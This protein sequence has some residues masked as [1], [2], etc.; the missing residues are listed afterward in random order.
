MRHRVRKLTRLLLH[1]ED[2]H[3]RTALAFG[4]GVFIGLSPLIG[5]H[6]ALGLA[7]AVFFRLNRVAV[8]LGVYVNNPWTF[9]PIYTAGTL[10]GCLLTG[11]SPHGIWSYDW[12]A[13][14]GTLIAR[15]LDVA[16]HYGWPFFIGSFVFGFIVAVLSYCAVRW[17]LERSGI[18]QEIAPIIEPTATSDRP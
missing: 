18:S 16:S 2:S 1:V 15:L 7:I 4:V 8:L 5:L 10:L 6:T 12:H 13:A 17:M 14:G 3:H 9:W 11:I